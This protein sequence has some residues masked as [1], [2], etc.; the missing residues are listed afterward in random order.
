M[1]PVT[2]LLNIFRRDGRCTATWSED[3]LIVAG[4]SSACLEP[5]GFSERLCQIGNKLN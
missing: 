2:P 1:M 3:G 5:F 4:R